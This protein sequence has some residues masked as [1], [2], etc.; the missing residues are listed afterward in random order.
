MT[1]IKNRPTV[2]PLADTWVSVQTAAGTTGK[3]T[4]E[5]VAGAGAIR[6]SA[7]IDSGAADFVLTTQNTWYGITTMTAGP[8]HGIAFDATEA[9]GDCF[10]IEVAGEYRVLF[11]GSMTAKAAGDAGTYE[12]S[13][14][15]DGVLCT[16]GC[17]SRLAWTGSDVG[18]IV[19]S[20]VPTLA[21]GQKVSLRVRC[22]TAATQTMILNFLSFTI[23]RFGA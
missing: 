10:I 15:I 8:Q 20:S 2:S 13:V 11:T 7:Y 4:A 18:N 6:G 9:T 23:E 22:T 1:Q 21:V 17:A 3:A 16:R 14:F 5:A 12:T 19:G